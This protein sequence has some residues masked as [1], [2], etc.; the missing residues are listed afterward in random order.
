M[1][2]IVLREMNPGEHIIRI[3]DEMVIDLYV[4]G[5]GRP[6]LWL[7][8]GFRGRNGLLN[9]FRVVERELSKET[10]L[11]MHLLP[12]LP[13]FG[14]S[15]PYDKEGTNP[16][17]FAKALG[18]LLELIDCT[19]LS[20]VGYSLG[21]NTAAVL[22]N[23]LEK[24]VNRLILLSTAIEGSCLS[25]YRHLI[26]LWKS[27]MWDEIIEVIAGELVGK[28]NREHYRRMAPL[29][30]KQISSEE[31]A[32]DLSRILIANTRIDVFPEI[33]KLSC[34]TLMIS[35]EDDPFVLSPEKRKI[36]ASKDNIELI[37]LEGIG[38]NELVFPKQVDLTR[39]ILDFL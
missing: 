29:L 22:A 17:L 31:F 32:N 26:D 27:G 4:K 2:K 30:R 9:L 38:H 13:G 25:I 16:Y 24:K 10:E 14:R 15:T 21:A 35:G 6:I 7:H 12:N 34:P 8:S 5:T 11:R 19:T 36:I 1:R 33:E 37:I 28:K 3:N 20:I 39:K 23:M 18:Q